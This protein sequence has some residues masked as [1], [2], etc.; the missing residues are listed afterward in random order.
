M[1]IANGRSYTPSKKDTS[2]SSTPS[3]KDTGTGK[4]ST[5]IPAKP[6]QGSYSQRDVVLDKM[7][8]GDPSSK[9]SQPSNKAKAN[10]APKLSNFG[11]AFKSARSSGKSEFSFGGKKYNTKIKG[12]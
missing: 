9:A 10:G 5:P 7:L 12:E 8:G 1:A 3:N 11:S 2:K 6:R 4:S